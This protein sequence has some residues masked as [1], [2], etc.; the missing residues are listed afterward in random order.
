MGKYS[1]SC[2]EMKCGNLVWTPCEHSMVSHG[3]VGF[4]KQRLENVWLY[5][6]LIFQICP[7][8]CRLLLKS[9][10]WKCNNISSK[11]ENYLSERQHPLTDTLIEM[12]CLTVTA[13][14][15]GTLLQN[16]I[17]STLRIWMNNVIIVANAWLVYIDS[18][19]NNMKTFPICYF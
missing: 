18:Y 19:V 5:R 17:L 1:I 4:I 3:R 16:Y 12:C 14:P 2:S 6:I 11:R 8:L 9:P 7:D 15:L 13:C 10:V